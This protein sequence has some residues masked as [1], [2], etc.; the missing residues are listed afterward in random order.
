MREEKP[1]VLKKFLKYLSNTKNYSKN[2][3]SGYGFDL[4][5]F[6]RFL[7]EYMF[8]EI[9]IKNINVFILAQVKEKDIIRFLIYLACEKDNSARTRNRKLSALKVFFK[10]LYTNYISLKDKL[11]PTQYI[12]K[13][14]EMIRLPK[15]LREED[16]KKIQNIFNNNNSKNYIRNNTIITLFLQTGMRLSELKNINIKDIDFENKTIKIVGKGNEERIVYLNKVAINTIKKYLDTRDYNK[17]ESLF[18]NKDNNRLSRKTIEN[19]C[20]Q[21]FKLANIE[22]YNYT[23]HTLRHTAA[24]YIYKETKDILVV[25]NILGHKRLSSTEIY[26]HIINDEI[27]EA[28]NKHPLANFC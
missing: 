2:T 27:K 11:N 25:K 23:T 18:V 22:E 1:T 28:F 13:P 14:E 6:F 20:G 12:N 8:S 19:I 9:E 7:C 10:Y 24:T 15:Y 21:A 26:T 17:N 4:I 3:V 5:I 16:A